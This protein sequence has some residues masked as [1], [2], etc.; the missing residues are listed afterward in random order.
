VEKVVEVADGVELFINPKH[1]YTEALLSAVPLSNPRAQHAGERIRLEGDIT[2]PSNPPSGCN[3][4][5]RCRYMQD[6]CTTETPLLRDLGGN[7]FVSCHF[8]DQLSLTAMR[9]V[10]Q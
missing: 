4:H 2:D 5:P 6:I 3:F 7:H 9:M 10:N 8:A 1:P